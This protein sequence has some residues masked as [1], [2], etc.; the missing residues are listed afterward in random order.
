MV[1]SL[2][3]ADVVLFGELHNDPI[4]H[5]LQRSLLEEFAK[6]KDRTLIVGAEMFE[7]DNQQAVQDYMK[8]RIDE[9][10]FDSLARFW[11]NYDTDYKPVLEYAKTIGAD[12]IATNVPRRYASMVYRGGFE[13]L[14]SL[15]EEEKS[16]IAPLPFPYDANL[17]GYV[18]MLE[19]MGGH[20]GE[21][22]PKAQ[23]IKDATMGYFIAESMKGKEKPL[24]LHLNGSYHSDNFEGIVWYL[25]QY[26][27]ELKV[28]TVT[29][30]LEENPKKLSEENKAKASYTIAVDA[31]MPRTY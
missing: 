25:Q 23:A 7:A 16:W 14:D 10:A 19:M 21:N 15:S 30:V 3:K 20:G 12:F 13:A 29:T 11:P 31:R 24:F 1:K 17:P 27:P 26:A 28:M 2:K 22:F 8:S 5:F 18:A 4:A 6:E 9:A